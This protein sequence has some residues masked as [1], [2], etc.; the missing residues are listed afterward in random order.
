MTI[1]ILYMCLWSYLTQ[2][3]FYRHYKSRKEENDNPGRDNVRK[4]EKDSPE[5]DDVGLKI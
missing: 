3:W 4:K 5:R 2:C 1:T